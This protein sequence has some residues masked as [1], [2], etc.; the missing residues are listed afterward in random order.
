MW[1]ILHGCAVFPS[2]GCFFSRIPSSV[3]GKQTKRSLLGK[4]SIY[5]PWPLLVMRVREKGT[6]TKPALSRN[7]P[8]ASMWIQ[9]QPHC[10]KRH[11][12]ELFF[13]RF[14]FQINK[15]H[16]YLNRLVNV[17]LAVGLFIAATWLIKHRHF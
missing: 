2:R 11:Y 13:Y 5:G 15:C 8:Y 7:M 3:C 6:L 16:K 17:S 1:C 9:M 4:F 12:S 14:L 10:H